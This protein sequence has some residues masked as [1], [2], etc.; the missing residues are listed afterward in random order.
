MSQIPHSV[1]WY[2]AY[3]IIDIPEAYTMS[4]GQRVS[5][6]IAVRFI[7]GAPTP[8]PIVVVLNGV[9]IPDLKA[10]IDESYRGKKK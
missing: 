5:L 9:D 10:D 1:E 4:S 3:A 8:I 2:K 7:Y 6:Y